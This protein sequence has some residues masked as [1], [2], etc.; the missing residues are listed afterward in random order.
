MRPC[1]VLI[2]LIFFVLSVATEVSAEIEAPLT[3]GL[4]SDLTGTNGPN[5]DAC[6]HGYEVAR[7]ISVPMDGKI[8]SKL[9]FVFGDHKGEPKTG[10][11][12]YLR[13]T[14]ME[15][16]VAIVSNRGNVGMAIDPLSS[17]MR[18]PLLGIMGHTDFVRQNPYGFRFWPSPE[19]EGQ[20][21][22]EAALL[23]GKTVGSIA[24]EEEYILSVVKGFEA[25]YSRNGG[26]MVF[27]ETITE[28]DNDWSTLLVRLRGRSPDILFL[29]TTVN[30]L[31]PLIKRTRELGLKQP[32]LSNFWLSYRSVATSAGEENIEGASYVTL[33]LARPKFLLEFEKLFPREQANAVTYACFSGLT[34]LLQNL[35]RTIL[36][37]EKPSEAIFAEL[38][39]ARVVKL[40]DEQVALIDREVQF[41]LVQEVYHFGKAVKEK[42]VVAVTTK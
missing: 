25:A 4:L 32:I 5:G 36:P 22:A 24:L 20:A 34:F 18:I 11:S 17:R 41:H 19:Q 42:E 23:R 30:K 13:L 28:Q 38:Q 14:E 26:R 33:D 6:R 39:K 2:V 29:N 37:K 31:G 16:A 3:V 35:P 21:L 27:R 15:G 12:E 40:P 1:C 7:K 8:A 9:R 10:V